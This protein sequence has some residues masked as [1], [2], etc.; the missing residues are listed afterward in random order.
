MGCSDDATA[1]HGRLLALA[2]QPFP[3]P[4]VSW[5]PLSGERLV[6][7][8]APCRSRQA[9]VL[10]IAGDWLEPHLSDDVAPP[11]CGWL[12]KGVVAASQCWLHAASLEAAQLVLAELEGSGVL[13]SLLQQP[14]N[15]GGGTG[16]GAGGGKSEEA[17]GAGQAHGAAAGLPDCSGWQLVVA[18][19]GLGAGA[20]A[21]LALKLQPDH[22]SE[23]V[24]CVPAGCLTG[25]SLAGF[26]P[27]SAG[28][29]VAC[30]SRIC[31]AVAQCISR[32]LHCVPCWRRPGVVGLCPSRPAMQPR[33]GWR[34]GR[35]LLLRVRVFGR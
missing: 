6:P 26:A 4:A 30:G 15:A 3:C 35:R 12:G 2:V 31:L 7:V 23:Q 18:G 5:P 25:G 24:T 20:A 19:H 14:S 16:G 10:G 17:A 21:A 34:A 1:A 32:V 11:P 33:A 22:S 9:V 8:A 27:G 13:R 29:G 28:E